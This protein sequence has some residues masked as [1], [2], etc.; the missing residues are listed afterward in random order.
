MLTFAKLFQIGCDTLKRFRAMRGKLYR[1]ELL[2][3]RQGQNIAVTVF[4][5]PYSFDIG[6]IKFCKAPPAKKAEPET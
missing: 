4:Y 6:L 2:P 1:F 5:V 3:E